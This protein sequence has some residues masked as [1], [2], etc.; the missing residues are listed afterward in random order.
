MPVAQDISKRLAFCT[1]FGSKRQSLAFKFFTKDPRIEHGFI[2][3]G[4]GK[5]L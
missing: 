2:V 3:T 4:I 5:E 1:P